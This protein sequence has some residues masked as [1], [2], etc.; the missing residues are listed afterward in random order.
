MSRLKPCA[1]RQI[2]TDTIKVKIR[3]CARISAYARIVGPTFRENQL[4]ISIVNWNWPFSRDVLIQV[5]EI[6]VDQE[7]MLGRVTQLDGMFAARPATR[8]GRNVD[9]ENVFVLG[10]L[11]YSI[12]GI[13]L[14]AYRLKPTCFCALRSSGFNP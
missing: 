1:G 3:F 7:L 13:N 4:D 12:R 2:G 10:R 14:R 9:V 11:D 5:L 6:I 8:L